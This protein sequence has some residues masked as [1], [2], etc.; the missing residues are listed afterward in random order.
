MGQKLQNNLDLYSRSHDIHLFPEYIAKLFFSPSCNSNAKLIKQAIKTGK[1]RVLRRDT[2]LEVGFGYGTNLLV[3]QRSGC[4]YIAG[5]ELA[6]RVVV[7]ADRYF[8]PRVKRVSFKTALVPPLPF[9]GREF[10]IVVCSHVLEH[11]DE[12]STLLSEVNRLLKPEGQLLVLVPINELTVDPR[13]C[14]PYSAVVFII[15]D[16]ISV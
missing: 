14:R 15:H 1:L 9:A 8:R 7:L 4:G 12:E 5:V 11:I 13:H 10:D 3:F 2:V 6:Q 16:T